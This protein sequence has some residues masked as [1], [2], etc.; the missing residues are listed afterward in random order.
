MSSKVEGTNPTDEILKNFWF[1]NNFKL[2]E[3]LQGKSSTKNTHIPFTHTHLLLTFCPAC[4]IICTLCIYM[5]IHTYIYTHPHTAFFLNCLR[6][7]CLHHGP[8]PPYSVFPNRGVLLCNHSAVGNLINLTLIWHFY[9]I[10]LY[11]IFVIWPNYA[12]YTIFPSSKRSSLESGVALT[13]LDSLVF[14]R[15]VVV[16]FWNQYTC[17]LVANWC[18]LFLCIVQ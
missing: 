3:R 11:S 14:F 7:S 5:H 12:L 4:F 1:G 13:C 15:F 8:F 2:T 6:V 16:N 17:S 18:L 10:Y 9:L